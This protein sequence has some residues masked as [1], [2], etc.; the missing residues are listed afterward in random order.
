MNVDEQG[1]GQGGST[2][3]RTDASSGRGA[4]WTAKLQR[5]TRMVS[6]NYGEAPRAP[7]TTFDGEQQSEREGRAR[8]REREGSAS[9]L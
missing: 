8:G 5:G 7:A 4:A 1:A 6:T 9:N 2:G 3:R